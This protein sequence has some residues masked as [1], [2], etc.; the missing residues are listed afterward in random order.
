MLRYY[1]AKILKLMLKLMFIRIITIDTF[2]S[3]LDQGEFV[4]TIRKVKIKTIILGECM[5]TFSH[6]RVHDKVMF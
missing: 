3:H 4:E 2:Y 6:F 1:I 5:W